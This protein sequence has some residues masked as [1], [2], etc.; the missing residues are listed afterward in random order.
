MVEDSPG[1]ELPN[2][3][4]FILQA[5]YGKD[6]TSC[7]DAGAKVIESLTRYGRYS[8]LIDLC[9]DEGTPPF[10][11][12]EARNN[13]LAAAMTACKNSGTLTP[14]QDVAVRQDVPLVIALHAG[15]ALVMRYSEPYDE[16]A[17][18]DILTDKRYHDKACSAAGEAIMKQAEKEL[19]F[20]TLFNLATSPDV[21]YEVKKPAGLLLIKLAVEQGNYPILL[22][23]EGQKSLP[24]DIRIALEDQ[25]QA[26]AM[27]SIEL[28][29]A[30]K[31]F[32]ILT[33]ISEDGRLPVSIRGKA[34]GC[35][36]D[37]MPP[38]PEPEAA[39]RPDPVM[40]AELMMRLGV[41]AGA[42]HTSVA[43][44]AS[45]ERPTFRE[46]PARRKH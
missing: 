38:T 8:V 27:T 45:S 11:A 22:A 15:A 26:A 37:S 43:P 39:E 33:D 28:A 17:L 7:R 23:M 31:D 21:I 4:P 5:K 25:V 40:T 13:I 14:L 16:K 9:K 34:M 44:P 10:L 32:A 41:S 36:H 35:L 18:W 6:E 20:S 46:P 24:V 29:Y 42:V 19:K 3:T 12:E 2:V 1:G 30:A